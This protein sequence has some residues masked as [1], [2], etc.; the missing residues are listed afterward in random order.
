LAQV[1]GSRALSLSD[2]IF[3]HLATIRLLVL[4]LLHLVTQVLVHF[5]TCELRE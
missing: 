1:L 4:Q 3:D 5:F 2:E